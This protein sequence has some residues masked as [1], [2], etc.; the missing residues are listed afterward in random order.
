M[1]RQAY[2][3]KKS[4]REIENIITRI[5]KDYSNILEE[6]IESSNPLFSKQNFEG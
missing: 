4:S 1:S 5:L 2:P 6:S 3:I